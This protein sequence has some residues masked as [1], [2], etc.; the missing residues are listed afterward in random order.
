MA[1]EK[2]KNGDRKKEQKTDTVTALVQLE[3]RGI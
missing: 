3:K 1:E 2:K